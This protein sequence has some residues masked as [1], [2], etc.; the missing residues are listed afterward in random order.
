MPSMMTND[1]IK[2]LL[3][4]LA[5]NVVCPPPVW[6]MRQA[7]RHL[8][9]YRALREEA[10]GFLA[11][12]YNPARAI[13]VTMQPVRRYNMDAAILFSDILVVPHALGQELWFAEGEGPKLGFL[14]NV[15]K[16]GF[17]VEKFDETAGPVYE[18]VKGIRK[19]LREEGFD[20]TALIG[21]AGAPW[22]VVTY[23]VEGGSSRTFEKTLLMARKEEK[24]FTA[25][26]DIITSATIHYLSRQIEA[27][28]E[29]V[30]IFDSWAG[31]LDGTEFEKWVILPTARIV[32]ALREQYPEIPVIGFPRGA[33]KQYRTYAKKT[34]VTALAIDQDVSLQE[35]QQLQKI[36]PVQG[37]LD[38]EI[39]LKGGK[40]MESAVQDLLENLSEGPYI[41]NLGHGVIKE[42]PPEHVQQLVFLIR[43][44]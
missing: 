16:T 18:A 27:G 28:A 15:E 38:P 21:F 31:A 13:E 17:V 5:G 29:A 40:E 24:R 44:T 36:C 10:G 20:K 1:S 12:A 6:L 14:E 43:R 8:P 32:A 7:G 33:K 26:M 30:K 19:A 4:V 23:M 25:L 11:M 34:K 22:T 2:P 42:T 9:E 41:F 39:V 3:S 35:A 37:N